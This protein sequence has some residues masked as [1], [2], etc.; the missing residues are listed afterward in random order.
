MKIMTFTFHNLCCFVANDIFVA[1]FVS[2][3]TRFSRHFWVC[4]QAL[5]TFNDVCPSPSSFVT[6]WF[7]LPLCVMTPFINKKAANCQHIPK[8][9]HCNSCTATLSLHI[10][11]GQVFL[12]ILRYDSTHLLSEECFQICKLQISTSWSCKNQHLLLCFL[13]LEWK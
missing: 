6:F 10:S 5:N 8:K 1:K 2:R 9:L 7:P 11:L 13:T 3:N 12:V 4:Y